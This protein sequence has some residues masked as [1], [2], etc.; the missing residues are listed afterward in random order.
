MQSNEFMTSQQGTESAAQPSPEGFY[1]AFEDKFRGSRELIVSRLKVYLPFLEPLKRIS[2]A[3]TAVDLGCGRGEW[4]ELL[5]E[6]GF[7]GQGVDLDANMLLA[8]QERGLHVTQGDAIQYL[9][10]LPS[11]SQLIVSGFHIAE[12]IPFT[13]LQTLIKEALRVLKPAGLLILETPNPENFR[14]SSVDFYLDPSHQN[15]LPPLLLSFVPEYYGFARVKI[16]R[17]Q[18]ESSLLHAENISLNQAIHGAS[19]DYAVVAQK[20]ADASSMDAFDEVFATEF[21][22]S[23]S[24]LI[25]RY[26]NDR[27][28]H[29]EKLEALHR[30]LKKVV[31]T[32]S[33]RIDENSARMVEMAEKISF[34]GAENE[35]RESALVDLRGQ[36]QAGD[37]AWKTLEL[38]HRQLS[39][40][41][42]LQAQEMEALRQHKD[43]SEQ[44]VIELRAELN[45]IYRS[46]SWRVTKP[47]R[48][49]GRIVSRGKADPK[50]SR[51]EN[52]PTVNRSLPRRAVRRV[53]FAGARLAQRNATARRVAKGLMSRAP[54]SLRVRLVAFYG[55]NAPLINSNGS[56]PE[57]TSP[58]YSHADHSPAVLGIYSRM[59]SLISSYKSHR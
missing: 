2:A 11:E 22:V 14:V 12:H 31:E 5:R 21:G 8:S 20:H 18:E 32:Q 47:L 28:Q 9:R 52:S 27:A 19:R 35:R 23:A 41:H 54:A 30:R 48:F 13:T 36:L 7:E 44:E 56:V 40:S 37:M 6:N 43:A 3:P 50:P 39:R 42:Q 15:P 51:A 38:E 24:A 46:K 57:S 16:V 29:E 49:A 1:R 53:L 58:Q 25:Q 10:N 33:H 4:L 45:A 34:L 17:L 55:H 26:D 59:Q